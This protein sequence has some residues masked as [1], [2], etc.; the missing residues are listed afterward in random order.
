[1]K[2]GVLRQLINCQEPNAFVQSHP[3]LIGG[4][5][6]KENLAENKK[7]MTNCCLKRWGKINNQ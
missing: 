2:E 4:R 6:I 5:L 3:N 1:M 7:E